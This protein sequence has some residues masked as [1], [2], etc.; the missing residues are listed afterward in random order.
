MDIRGIGL[1][2]EILDQFG[3]KPGKEYKVKRVVEDT[4]VFKIQEDP[5]E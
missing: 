2:K 5:E 1:P 3:I 4:Y